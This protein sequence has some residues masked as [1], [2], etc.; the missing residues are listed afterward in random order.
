[1]SRLAASMIRT[2]LATTII[3]GQKMPEA[4]SKCDESDALAPEN[5]AI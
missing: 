1:M 5:D 4:F 2:I 3:N